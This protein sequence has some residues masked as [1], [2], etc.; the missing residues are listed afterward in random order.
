[1]KKLVA[2]LSLLSLSACSLKYKV[3][4]C[5]RL[6]PG[7]HFYHIIKVTDTTLKTINM[8]TDKLVALFP[9]EERPFQK[10]DCSIMH[11]VIERYKK[12]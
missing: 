8:E 7:N 11:E 3:G 2:I 6:S 9:G 10:V 5:V 1:M 12:K 4:E